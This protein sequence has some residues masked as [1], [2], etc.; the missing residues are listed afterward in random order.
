MALKDNLTINLRNQHQAHTESILVHSFFCVTSRFDL[1]SEMNLFPCFFNQIEPPASSIC[2]QK[3][4]MVVSNVAATQAHR[5][6]CG[7]CTEA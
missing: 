2:I 6:A 5:G 1:F 7:K 4:I 3:I